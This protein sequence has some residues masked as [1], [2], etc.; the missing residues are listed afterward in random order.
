MPKLAY[1]TSIFPCIDFIDIYILAGARMEARVWIAL[2]I[3]PVTVH[4]ITTDKIVNVRFC[5]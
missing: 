1:G 5:N 4:Q 3:I 2:S